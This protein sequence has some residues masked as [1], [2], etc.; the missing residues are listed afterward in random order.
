M[1]T[2][3]PCLLARV[4]GSLLQRGIGLLELWPVQQ[5][6]FVQAQLGY[7]FLKLSEERYRNPQVVKPCCTLYPSMRWFLQTQGI[8]V[9]GDANQ[10]QLDYRGSYA[11][12]PRDV[13]DQQ[14]ITLDSLPI[15]DDSGCMRKL[16]VFQDGIFAIARK[17]RFAEHKDPEVRCQWGLRTLRG[18]C[19]CPYVHSWSM[20]YFDI[21]SKHA[22][23]SV[24]AFHGNLGRWGVGRWSAASSRHAPKAAAGHGDALYLGYGD[25]PRCP[26]D[27]YC[28]GQ[29]LEINNLPIFVPQL[30]S[31]TACM[32]MQGAG[33]EVDI[34]RRT[35]RNA[36]QQAADAERA[37]KKAW[38]ALKPWTNT[39]RVR[40]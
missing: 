18:G 3:L 2:A 39:S 17:C 24:N 37:A 22:H 30:F 12:A 26:R 25:I 9:I 5:L 27:T 23:D 28:L 40:R 4:I 35:K 15:A 14:K 7:E 16:I 34:S 32:A 29:V 20:Q 36:W 19:E 33:E 8:Y 31:H 6:P 11:D 21:L 10:T 13:R 38:N 1:R